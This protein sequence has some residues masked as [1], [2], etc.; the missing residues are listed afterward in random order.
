VDTVRVDVCYRPL[1]IG[2]A[3]K[4]GDMAALR[5]A[6]R[7]S[8]ALRGGRFNPIIIADQREQS[9]ALIDVF[10]VDLILPFGDSA[11][12]AE[13]PKNFPHLITPFFHPSVFVD[14]GDGTARS[15]GC[16]GGDKATLT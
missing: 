13:F 7:A 15:Q 9:K 16:T 2:W 12:V 4:S 11:Q 6:V 1:R 8:F 14:N 5:D 3:I 10:R